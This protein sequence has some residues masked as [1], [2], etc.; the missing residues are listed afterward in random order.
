M[1]LTYAYGIITVRAGEVSTPNMSRRKRSQPSADLNRYAQR[2][3][4]LKRELQHLEYFCKGTVLRRMVKCGKTHCACRDDPAK[5]HGPYFEWTYKVRG[6]TVNV[7]LTP[8]AMPAYRAA[9]Q[10][11]RKLKLVLNRL[12]RLSKTVLQHQA[13]MSP[14]TSR[15]GS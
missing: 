3:L 10:E 13:R 11:Y 1:L 6:K 9:S 8:E 4:E 15:N 2:F 14:S 5:R 12:E 7:K